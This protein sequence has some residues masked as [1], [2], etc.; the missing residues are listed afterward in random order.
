MRSLLIHNRF[1]HLETVLDVGAEEVNDL[2][3]SFE[4]ISSP[5]DLVG[6]RTALQ[7]ARIDYE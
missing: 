3:D 7:A 2:G 4:V 5:T 1:S 6:V